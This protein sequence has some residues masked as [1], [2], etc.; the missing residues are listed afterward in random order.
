M[1]RS[2]LRLSMSKAIEQ[3]LADKHELTVPNCLR[4][5]RPCLSSFNVRKDTEIGLDDWTE[6]LEIAKLSLAKPPSDV[7]KSSVTSLRHRAEGHEWKLR[8]L[9]RLDELD[10]AGEMNKAE[11]QLRRELLNDHIV[12]DTYMTAVRL[13]RSGREY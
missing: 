2:N 6:A 10:L 1:S 4:Y 5:V 13:A 7:Q 3:I 11:I 9:K 12:K 8:V